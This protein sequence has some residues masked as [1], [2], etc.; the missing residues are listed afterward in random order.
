MK[1]DVYSMFSDINS[2]GMSG[3][4]KIMSKVAVTTPSK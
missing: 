4:K 2:I 1:S 3:A